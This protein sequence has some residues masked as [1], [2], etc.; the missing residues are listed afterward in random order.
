MKPRKSDEEKQKE[1][2]WKRKGEV[3]TPTSI[4]LS[5]NERAIIEARAK[6]KGMK[7]TTYMV[8]AAVHGSE[9]IDP[10]QM[11]AIQNVMNYAVDVM[12][13]THPF[14]A[15]KLEREVNDLWQKLL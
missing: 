6:E 8:Y 15:E 3:S 13:K 9:G 14:T 7:L 11:V 1:L 10:K 5:P 12:K 2:E 4:R